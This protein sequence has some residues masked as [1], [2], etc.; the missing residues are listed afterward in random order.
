L[1]TLTNQRAVVIGKQGSGKTELCRHILRSTQQHLVYDRTGHDYAGFIR[2]LPEDPQSAMEM[3][4]VVQKHVIDA[5]PRPRLF[6]LD[7]GNAFIQPKPSR[8][9]PA[10]AE[11]NDLSRHMQL[12][13][14]VATRRPSQF[15]SDIME[16]ADY[17]FVY[18]LPG[19][20]DRS[21]LNDISAHLG[22]Y[23]VDLPTY[24][25]LVYDANSGVTTH[26][27]PIDIQQTAQLT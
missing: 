8:L 24:H 4:A 20:K 25:F 10:I 7:E 3:N 23:A 2:Y 11:L 26:H 21:A 5:S 19:P 22:D 17:I 27:A 18:R 1:I 13:W 15:H 16:L 6:V 9:P 12:S 14:V